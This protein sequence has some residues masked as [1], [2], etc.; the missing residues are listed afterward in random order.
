MSFIVLF[1]GLHLQWVGKSADDM[2]KLRIPSFSSCHF[3]PLSFCLPGCLKPSW[4]RWRHEN[5]RPP[6]SACLSEGQQRGG[7]LISRLPVA[8]LTIPLRLK[9]RVRNPHWCGR[10]ISPLRRSFVL[11]DEVVLP[12]VDSNF[13]PAPPPPLCLSLMEAERLDRGAEAISSAS[14]ANAFLHYSPTSLYKSAAFSWVL[15]SG[16]SPRGTTRA[17]VEAGR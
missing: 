17:D 16:S 7:R 1:V 6:R 10:V 9:C 15:L 2:R 8:P 5:R 12:I 4:I 14:S 13:G 3:S 11:P